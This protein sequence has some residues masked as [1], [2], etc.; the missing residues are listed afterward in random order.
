MRTPTGLSGSSSGGAYSEIDEVGVET[1]GIG[2]GLTL[3]GEVGLA[4]GRVGLG[5]RARANTNRGDAIEDGDCVAAG[6]V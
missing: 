2:H 4:T 1:A 6:T 3:V 5:L